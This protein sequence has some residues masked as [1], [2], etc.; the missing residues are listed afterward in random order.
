MR[1]LEHTNVTLAPDDPSPVVAISLFV[2]YSIF[3]VIIALIPVLTCWLAICF[4]QASTKRRQRA[5]SARRRGSEYNDSAYIFLGACCTFGVLF[6]FIGMF[7]A[8]NV[9]V[10]P[11]KQ[12][13]KDVHQL[14]DWDTLHA[15][16]LLSLGVIFLVWLIGALLTTL[17][18]RNFDEGQQELTQAANQVDTT[19]L[20][21]LQHGQIRLLR[22]EWLRATYLAGP[23]SA[24]PINMSRRQELPEEA[25]FGCEE[26]RELYAKNL[27]HDEAPGVEAVPLPSVGGHHSLAARH[28]MMSAAAAKGRGR[29]DIVDD[30]HVF[31]LSYS[32]LSPKHC[33]PYGHS[34]RVVLA[35]LLGQADAHVAAGGDLEAFWA[36]SA[37]F[38]DWG[39]MHQKPRDEDEEAD[40]RASLLGMGGLCEFFRMLA[41]GPTPRPNAQSQ[42]LSTARP[43]LN[44]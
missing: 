15:S 12:R 7:T 29:D 44:P 14:D 4:G 1:L 43:P 13:Y 31:V 41:R 5:K 3:A 38:W 21:L 35:F 20:D 24:P 28:S 6:A 33:D 32:W 23:E 25:F 42:P 22:C 40:F 10:S 11:L 37:L 18:L 39:S 17:L 16:A 30:A 19:V 2:A 34:L 27:T 26:A 36:G 9:V 8:W